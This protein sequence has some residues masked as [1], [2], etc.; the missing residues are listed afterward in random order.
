VKPTIDEDIR[1]RAEEWGRAIMADHPEVEAVAVMYLSR[2]LVDVLPA[3]IVVG[4][5]GPPLR[6]DQNVRLLEVW[7]RVGMQLLANHQ[8]GVK[9][10]DEMLGQYARRL[11]DAQAAADAGQPRR[12][13]GPAQEGGP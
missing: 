6:P 11:A 5:K 9:A 4:G 7:T 10:L 1:A 3:Q 2:H 12:P 8:Q 13:A